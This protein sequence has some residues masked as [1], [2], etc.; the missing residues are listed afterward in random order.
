MPKTE[1]PLYLRLY[2]AL[3]D[4]I[5]SGAYAPGAKLPGKRTL[6]EQ[7]GLSTVTAEHALSL[8][9]DEG[10]IEQRPRSGS[11]VCYGEGAAFS[12]PAAQVFPAPAA[13]AVPA[14]SFSFTALAK[15]MRGVIADYGEGLLAKCPNA[16]APELRSALAA[17]LLRSRG[18]EVSP[19]QIVIG[20]GA[21]HLYTT[22]VQMLGRDRVYAVEAPSY[23]KIEAVYRAA[24]VRVEALALGPDGIK[25]ESLWASGA[26]VLHITPYRSFPS[27]VTAS[28]G[29]R[30]EYLQWAAEHGGT[31]VEDDFESEFTPSTKPERTVFALSDRQNVIYLNTFTKTLGPGV[32]VG[33]LVLPQPL[34]ERYAR[35]AG[36]FSCA[37][38]AFEQYLIARLLDSGEF[39]R[40]LNR[41]RRRKRRP[42]SPKAADNK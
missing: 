8:L 24:G 1:G 39:E 12:H 5:E 42:E 16:G 14:E 40:H 9:A 21:E 3:R 18:M 32:R 19:D 20:A 37:V 31:V 2:A 4:R 36:R 6:A 34:T 28:A 11:Y 33:Y 38:P 22:V 35:T 17:Y 26:D 23:E 41:V 13:G 30:R 27:G 7:W 29:K 25:S 15:A 10:Y